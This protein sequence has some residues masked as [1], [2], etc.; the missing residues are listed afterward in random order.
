MIEIKLDLERARVEKGNGQAQVNT[1]RPPKLPAFV[2]GRDNLDVYINRFERYAVAQQWA[3][4]TWAVNLSALLTGKALDTYSRLDDDDAIDYN[5]VKAAI[6]KHY[7][8]TSEGF[9]RS[10]A[11]RSRNQ[12][13]QRSSSSQGYGAISRSG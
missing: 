9:R 1:V 7:S 2:C 10:S 8:L 5:T 12:G 3:P 6:L 4:D 11:V 13:K